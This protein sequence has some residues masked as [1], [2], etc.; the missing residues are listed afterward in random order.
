MAAIRIMI[1]EDE[2]I[3]RMGLR[4]M[5]QDRAM[6]SWAR[7]PTAR[8]PWSRPHAETGLGHHGHHDAGAGLHSTP[9]RFS[10][11]SALPRC[12]LG[13][14]TTTASWSACEG[15]GVFAYVYEALH[16]AP[17]RPPDRAGARSLP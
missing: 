7:P 5:L 11:P 2:A 1:A 3:P 10:T 15:R 8:P 17:A 4:E 14:P 12:L 6:L 9:P 13:L 16:R